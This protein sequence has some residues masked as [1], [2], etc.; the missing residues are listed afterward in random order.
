MRRFALI[1]AIA[2]TL[3]PSAA[4]ATTHS[5]PP[6]PAPPRQPPA[7]AASAAFGASAAFAAFGVAPGPAGSRADRLAALLARDPVQVTDHAPRELPADTEARIRAAVARLRVP[8]YVVVA[9]LPSSIDDPDT[10][11]DRLI[12]LLRDRL[13]KDGIYVVTGSSG[14]GTARQ[15]GGSLPVDRA[16]STAEYELPYDAT[17]AQVVERFVEILTAPDVEAR[18]E[19]RR[20]APEDDSPSRGEIRDRK[21]MAA[22]GA[23]ALVGGLPLLFLLF[24]QRVRRSRKGASA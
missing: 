3:L 9:P 2:L 6:A 23:G 5:P 10:R 7:S 17:V 19:H 12:P 13:G 22:M 15:Y 18:I 20:E 14:F 21:E 24:R 4:H 1:T 11:A 16:W 8:V